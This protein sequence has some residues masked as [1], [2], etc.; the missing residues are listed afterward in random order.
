MSD[1]QN[2]RLGFVLGETAT[3][4]KVVT[5]VTGDRDPG[6]GSTAKMLGE[7]A[8]ALVALP[9]A[10]CVGGFWTPSTAFGHDLIERLES[11]AG[12]EFSIK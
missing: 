6:Y 5:S 7:T 9:R 10:D 1:L 2:F 3:G 12:L 4:D 8:L 11:H